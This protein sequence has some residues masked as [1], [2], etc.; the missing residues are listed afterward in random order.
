MRRQWQ[1][2]IRDFFYHNH[3]HTNTKKKECFEILKKNSV[4]LFVGKGF[5]ID[6]IPSSTV[7]TVILLS[8]RA[9]AHHQHPFVSDPKTS[10]TFSP[11]C[12]QLCLNFV[13]YLVTCK[14]CHV[15]CLLI[16]VCFMCVLLLPP[17]YSS[18]N[19]LFT[20]RTSH[21]SS[22]PSF[23]IFVSVPRKQHVIPQSIHIEKSF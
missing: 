5:L 6:V 1:L 15:C 19:V 22:P 23:V 10:I 21:I 18:V 9:G 3:H 14:R 17:R 2:L 4:L 20:L 11:S 7:I 13:F 12:F 16:N 8:K